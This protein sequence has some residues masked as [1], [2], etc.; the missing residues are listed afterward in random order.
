MSYA[1]MDLDGIGPEM[2]AKL[3]SVGIRTTTKLLDAAKSARGRK[4]L[5]TKIGVDE[6]TVLAW[7]NLADRMR[8]KGVGEDYAGLL[9]AAGVDTVKELKYRNVE[10]LAQAMA[11]A[12]K[13]RKL[14]RVLPSEGRVRLWIEQ[15][16][17]L[18][19]KI[20]Y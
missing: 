10:N 5:A 2:A 20:S 13:K 12:N 8:I 14:V 15:A 19:L 1:I 6:K 11:T 4:D 3:K 17:Q 18:P 9:Q 7:A 16:K